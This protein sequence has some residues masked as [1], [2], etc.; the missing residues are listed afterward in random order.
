MATDTGVEH[1]SGRW[2]DTVEKKV[3]AGVFG[4]NI[5]ECRA[6][7][8]EDGVHQRGVGGDLHVDRR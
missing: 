3:I 7:F 6:Q 5:C 2:V 4:L 1:R 8:G